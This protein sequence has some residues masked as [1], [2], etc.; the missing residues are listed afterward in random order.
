MLEQPSAAKV[1]VILKTQDDWRSWIEDI[2]SI[3]LLSKVWGYIDP[4]K[5]ESELEEIPKE[6]EIPAD[7]ATSTEIKIFEINVLLKH[8]YI[9]NQESLYK[10][11][12]AL[13]KQFAPND[14]ELQMMAIRRYQRAKSTPIK[15]NP[16]AWFTEFE[17]AYY[18]MK[19]HSLPEAQDM[20]VI[21]DFLGAV[22][23]ASKK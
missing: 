21:R 9:N 4:S 10:V 13:K 19:Y 18:G 2:K 17:S 23:K 11:L 14:Q 1:S 3:A 7:T 12:K 16:E 6:P 15:S 22:M 8:F 20:Y 5:E